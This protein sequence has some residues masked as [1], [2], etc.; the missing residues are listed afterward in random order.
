MKSYVI[1]F[2]PPERFQLLMYRGGIAPAA[3][4]ICAA[5]RRRGFSDAQIERT[6]WRMSVIERSKLDWRSEFPSRDGATRGGARFD[7]HNK[8]KQ[9]KSKGLFSHE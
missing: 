2:D 9:R 3:R 6:S 5:L 4:D 8:V 7:E 1:E